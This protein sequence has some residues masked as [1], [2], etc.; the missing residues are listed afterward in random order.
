MVLMFFSLV[1]SAEVS[2]QHLAGSSPGHVICVTRVTSPILL[3]F[4]SSRITRHMSQEDLN[5]DWLSWHESVAQVQIFQLL[6]ISVWLAS[7]MPLSSHRRN[8]AMKSD[9]FWLRRHCVSCQ[10]SATRA[11]CTSNCIFTLTLKVML[12]Q[13]VLFAPGVITT[14]LMVGHIWPRGHN[15]SITDLIHVGRSFL[16]KIGGF[17]I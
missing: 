12:V 9:C 4:L 1:R 3:D 17:R 16:C 5:A 15:L 2:Q 11:E 10:D 6:W 7:F 14:V 8:S 13:L